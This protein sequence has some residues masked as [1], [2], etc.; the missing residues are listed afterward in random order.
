MFKTQRPAI[1]F[2]GAL[3]YTLRYCNTE[4]N[5]KISDE[6]NFRHIV[7]MSGLISSSAI[8]TPVDDIPPCNITILY[9]FIKFNKSL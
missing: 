7:K 1:D 9:Q 3:C 5:Y 8:I 2:S 6:Y 4:S